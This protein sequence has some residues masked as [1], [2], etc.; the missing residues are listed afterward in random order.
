MSSS[1]AALLDRLTQ[2]RVT[3]LLK[4]GRSFT[5]RLLGADEHLNVVLDE[6]EEHREEI[7]RRLGRVVLRGS[8]VVSLSSTAAAPPPR[9]G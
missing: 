2:Q 4:D 3:L 6:A 1:P 7:S 9:S 8:N 5:G